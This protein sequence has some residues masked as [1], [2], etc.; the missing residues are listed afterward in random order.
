[1]PRPILEALVWCLAVGLLLAVVAVAHQRRIAGASRRHATAL[2]GDLRARDL[3][4]RHL[5]E[6]RLPALAESLHE[7]S[8]QVPGPLHENIADSPYGHSQQRV[9]EQFTHSVNAAL[10]RADQSAQAALMTTMRALQSLA[11]DQQLVISAMQNRYDHPG[12]LAD[13]LKIDHANAQFGRRAQ[14]VAVL[15]G[16]WPGR[17]R[18]AATLEDVVRGAT[19]RISDYLRVKTIAQVDI[20]LS[21]RLVEPVVLAVAELLDNAARHSPP[22]TEVQVNIHPTHNGAV[23]VIDDCGVGMHEQ[24]KHRAAWLLSGSRPVDV[25]RLG[26]PPQFGFA[27][28][29]VLAKR[30][31]FTVSVD[32]QSPYG[33][34]RAVLYLPHPLLTH[35]N[36]HDGPVLTSSAENNAAS[37]PPPR[38]GEFPNAAA[39]TR[40]RTCRRPPTPAPVA[41]QRPE[42]AAPSWVPSNAGREPAAR[43]LRPK[44]M[45]PV[46]DSNNW[47]LDEVVNIPDARH[48]ILLSADG[49]LQAHSAGIGRDEADTYAAALSGLQS[50]SRATAE[51]CV[52]E[53]DTPWRQTLVEFAD[54]YVFLIAAGPGAYLA[55]SSTGAADMEA[56]T[57][58]M[59]SSSTGSARS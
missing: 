41:R 44:G 24:E 1:M 57:Y 56:V 14:A 48:A 39:V 31:G 52:D 46:N 51:F 53:P 29:G 49:M 3:E 59:Q 58:R 55:V 7:E 45:P 42:Q 34:V 40:S 36:V 50:I 27:V 11:S 17:Q 21:D 6:V 25:T 13:L 32:S 54:G 20:A 5:A 18:A 15:C 47:M 23:I 38:T 10:A 4:A 22:S 33:G 16:A 43:P 30:Y 8:V 35:L 37:K 9:V 19:S 12:I 28:I 2:R 26:D